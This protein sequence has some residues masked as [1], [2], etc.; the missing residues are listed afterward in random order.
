MKRWKSLLLALFGLIVL[1]QLPFAYRRYRLGRLHS[2][3]QQLASQRTAPQN[4]SSF[5]D[6]KG[7]IHV[8]TFL[9]GHSTGTF[10]ELISAAKTDELAFV[11]MTE[12]P[13]QDFDTS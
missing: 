2:A 10:T 12:H 7:V 5:V 8:H 3:I 11:I 1:S 6:Y 9:G 4:N 13:Q